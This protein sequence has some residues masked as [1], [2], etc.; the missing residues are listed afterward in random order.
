MECFFDEDLRICQRAAWP[1]GLIGKE[2]VQL[3]YPYIGRMLDNLKE[4]MHDAITRNTFRTFQFMDF[5]EDLEGRVFDI[6]M[7]YLMHIENA[8]ALRVFA[9]TTAAN[10]TIKYP[11]LAAELIPIIEEQLPHGSAGFKNRGAKLLN[12]LRNLKF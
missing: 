9:M 11:E 3:L 7:D 5:P 8:V 12:K 2:H 6:S 4:P 10:I 1:V